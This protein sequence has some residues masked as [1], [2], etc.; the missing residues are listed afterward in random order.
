VFFTASHRKRL[1]LLLQLLKPEQCISYQVKALLNQSSAD[2][3]PSLTMS[4]SA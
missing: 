2:F 4:S 3:N 1:S